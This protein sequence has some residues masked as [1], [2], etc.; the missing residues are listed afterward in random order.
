MVDRGSTILWGGQDCRQNQR[1]GRVDLVTSRQKE[2]TV[3]HRSTPSQ[4]YPRRETPMKDND[5]GAMEGDMQK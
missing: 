5:R 4:A 3:H 2:G 1:L